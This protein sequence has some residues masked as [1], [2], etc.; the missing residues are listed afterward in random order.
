[1][2]ADGHSAPNTALIDELPPGPPAL[3]PASVPI[4]GRSHA[5]PVGHAVPEPASAVRHPVHIRPRTGWAMPDLPE[6][7]RHRE[8]LGFFVWRDLKVRYKQTILGAAWALIQPL[9]ATL[10][11][12][13]IFGRLAGMPSD[14]VPYPIFSYVSLLIWTYFAGAL[15]Q[16]ANSVV[17]NQATITK[18]YFPRL[19][20]PVSAILPGL[21]DLAIASVLGLALLAFYD[22]T[23]SWRLLAAPF[24]VGLAALTALGAGLWLSAINVRFRDVRHMVPFLIQ[25]WLFASP[26]VFAT[27]LVPDQ[28]HTMYAINPLVGILEG[29]RWAVLGTGPLSASSILLSV[30]VSL[31][32]LI[33]GLFFFRTQ[34]RVFAD[35]A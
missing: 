33:S 2:R 10:L 18:V 1:M 16:A 8:L 6:L 12:A 27:S 32:L 30:L 23:L 5:T 22:V 14:G 29:F 4:S 9:A 25:F 20:I 17:N 21:L 31:A 35:V 3:G 19:L 11:F 24:F 26:V 13:V 34:E 15:T 7:W 28:W